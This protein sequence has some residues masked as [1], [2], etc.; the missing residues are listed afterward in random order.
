MVQKPRSVKQLT[1]RRNPT[2]FFIAVCRGA[3]PTVL[4]SNQQPRVS[5]PPSQVP[6]IGMRASAPCILHSSRKIL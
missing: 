6:N 1:P 5:G 2:K 3:L 4:S